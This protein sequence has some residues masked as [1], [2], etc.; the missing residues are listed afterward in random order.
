MIDSAVSEK[1]GNNPTRMSIRGPLA[2]ELTPSLDRSGALHS[3]QQIPREP[4]LFSDAQTEQRLEADLGTREFPGGNLRRPSRTAAGYHVRAQG[5][6]VLL[7]AFFKDWG[8]TEDGSAF[9][10]GYSLVE[11]REV[12][13]GIRSLTHR[14]AID[15]VKSLLRI[16]IILDNLFNGNELSVREWLRSSDD[17]LGGQTPLAVLLEG[18]LESVLRVKQVVELRAGH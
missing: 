10:L 3:D 6:I 4:P 1:Y 15:R 12:F 11:A 13:L 7:E 9:L 18:S 17:L 5:Q 16:G 8:C 14:D 2:S